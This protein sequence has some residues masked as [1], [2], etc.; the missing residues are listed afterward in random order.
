[1]RWMPAS[2]LGNK[3][4]SINMGK[5]VRYHASQ[6]EIASVPKVNRGNLTL[7]LKAGEA[8]SNCGVHPVSYLLTRPTHDTIHKVNR[9]STTAP[10]KTPSP[11]SELEE[12]LMVDKRHTRSGTEGRRNRCLGQAASTMELGI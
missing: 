9:N 4:K 5:K 2:L 11:V 8:T 3:M 1:M 12:E 7:I 10:A 6:R